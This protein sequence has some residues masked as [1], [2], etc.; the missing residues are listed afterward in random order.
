MVENHWMSH[1]LVYKSDSADRDN[2]DEGFLTRSIGHFVMASDL[3]NKWDHE[4]IIASL[5]VGER[6]GGF[7]SA[8][9]CYLVGAAARQKSPSSSRI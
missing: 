9:V 3:G 7:L 5:V 4:D 1:R 2:C 8:L 6:P